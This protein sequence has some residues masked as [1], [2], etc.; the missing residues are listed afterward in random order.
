MNHASACASLGLG[1]HAEPLTTRLCRQVKCTTSHHRF[2]QLGELAIDEFNQRAHVRECRT[3][4]LVVVHYQSESLLEHVDYTHNRHG[5]E[6]RQCAQQGGIQLES[7]GTAIQAQ[8]FVKN[9]K[10][11][12]F[13]IQCVAPSYHQNGTVA[14]SEKVCIIGDTHAAQPKNALKCAQSSYLFTV[15]PNSASL[16]G[17]SAFPRERVR[18]RSRASQSSRRSPSGHCNIRSRQRHRDGFELFLS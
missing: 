10:D 12:L 9:R 16:G 15:A 18:T 2:A 6:F 7:V 1:Q 13:R 8:D 4:N 11:F 14:R 3:I 17:F 5:V